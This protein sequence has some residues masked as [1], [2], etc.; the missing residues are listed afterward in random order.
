MKSAIPFILTLS[1]TSICFAQSN[2]TESLTI[3]TYYPAPYGVYR[4][5]RLHPSEAPTGA[6]KQPGVMYYDKLEN[7][8]KYWNNAKWINISDPSA[9]YALVGSAHI[10]SD[11]TD[12][13][14]EV[15]DSGTSFKIC[16]FN[17]TVTCPVGWNQ[18]RS[19]GTYVTASHVC[20]NGP[21]LHAPG[22]AGQPNGDCPDPQIAL[23][24]AWGDFRAYTPVCCYAP[25]FEEWILY[26]TPTQ[27]GC[28]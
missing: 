17:T 13:G 28:Y 1:L 19:F 20:D 2:Y 5:L 8:I 10:Q 4:N 26:A 14:G 3:T 12:A 15:V 22:C 9:G 18:Y 24:S 11:C 21:C 27:M 6:A 7:T 23:G 16:R 25:A